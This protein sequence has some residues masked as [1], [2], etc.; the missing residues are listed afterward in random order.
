MSLF[1]RWLAT[2]TIAT[3]INVLSPG[4]AI[5]EEADPSA[6]PKE[7]TE[8]AVIE[9]KSEL[10]T[11]D[12]GRFE[13]QDLGISM[14]APEGWEVMT[15]TAA[16]T[17]IINEPKDEK[18][19]Y[20]KPKYQRNITV[21]TAHRSTPIDATRAAELI[22]EMKVNFGKDP[23]VS[24]FQILEKRFFNYRGVNDGLLVYSGLKLGEY[25][26]MQMHILISGEN[27]QFL[28]SYTDLAE[29]FSDQSNGIFQQAWESMTSVEVTGET[30]LRRDMYIKYGAIAGISVLLLLLGLLR[31]RKASKH[32]Y[33]VDADE[34]DKGEH[35][36]ELTH[37]I[38]ATLHGSWSVVEDFDK[39]FQN[40]VDALEDEDYVSHAPKTKRT[41]YV[42]NY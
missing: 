21:A 22:E 33:T 8:E 18:P 39:D 17:A 24:D 12:G 11:S 4:I 10:F 34:I 1:P 9:D 30:P 42:S 25:D 19:S 20:D 5:A 13:I 38:I 37:S 31:T 6:T 26:M 41:E 14:T 28:I 36:N 27:N 29:R 7:N 40:D 35:S 16:L 15:N 32:D 23:L 2:S 3:C